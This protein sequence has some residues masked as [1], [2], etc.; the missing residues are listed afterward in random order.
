MIKSPL[1]CIIIRNHNSYD[2]SKECLDSILQFQYKNFKVIVVDDGSNDDSD[3][4]LLLEFPSIIM[5]KTGKYLEFCKAF[6]VG[7]RHAIKLNSDFIFIINND[8]KNFS[9]NYLDVALD[10]FIK[11]S[12][13]GMFG[14]T[15]FDFDGNKR[16]GGVLKRR[17]DIDFYTPTEGYIIP[18]SVLKEVGFFDEGLVRYFEDLDLIKRMYK[19][20]FTTFCEN[21]ISFDHL[22]GGITKNKPYIRNYYRIR[23]VIWFLKRYYS[24][25]NLIWSLRIFYQEMNPHFINLKKSIIKLNL[26]HFFIILYSI[27]LGILHGVF[28]KW[29]SKIY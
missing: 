6:N 5:L 10:V 25:R 19:K 17:F 8:T 15:V 11:D 14:S 9:K 29:N 22:G 12:K 16:S 23:N 27:I 4:K 28:L 2:L 21:S 13:I 18:A 1:F 24:Q 7:I 20:G 3:Q 26:K